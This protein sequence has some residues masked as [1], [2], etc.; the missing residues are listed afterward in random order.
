[1]GVNITNDIE[2]VASLSRGDVSAFNAFYKK[3][4]P[5]LYAFG[6]KMLKSEVE[7]EELVQSVFMTL[8]EK[9]K[10]L[11]SELSI[12]SFIF[13]IA[14]NDICKLF[15]RR[16]YLKEFIEETV[17]FQSESTTEM[18]KRIDAKLLLERIYLIINRLPQRQ[19][20]IFLKSREEGKTSKEIAAELDLS[21]G[22]IDNY[23]SASLKF[24]QSQLIKEGIVLK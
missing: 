12:R 22:T 8:W 13:T 4:S 18:E 10:S 2:L 17:N 3:Y 14:Y 9:R 20:E 15:R 16:K 5:S 11:N 21:P 24:I 6:L 19:K 1:M 7:S 23:I